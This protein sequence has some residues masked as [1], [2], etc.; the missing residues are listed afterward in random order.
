MSTIE[1]IT[2]PPAIDDEPALRLCAES[3][4]LILSPEEFDAVEDW[5]EDYRYELIRGVVVVNPIPACGE[6][7]PNEELGYWL[8][9]YRDLN[10][11]GSALD[12][13]LSEQFVYLPDG[14]RRRA[15]RLIWCGL[16]RLPNPKSDVATIGVE[17]V[18]RRR[19]DWRRDFI[20]KR[21]EYRG[22]GMKEYWV[23]DRF[24]RKMTVF[25]LDGSEK[26][27]DDNTTYDTPLL[28]GF[29]LPLGRLLQIADQWAERE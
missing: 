20:D 19:R 1:L 17:F 11:K 2:P 9:G 24:R 29:Q 15:D 16:G 26:T 27:I 18:S 28:P 6:R 8:L 21:G 25:L 4:G 23:I 14:S 5:D 7:G 3:N 13:T 22:V 10:P 12:A